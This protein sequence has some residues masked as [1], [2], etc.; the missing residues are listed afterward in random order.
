ML[1]NRGERAGADFWKVLSPE[2]KTIAYHTVYSLAIILIISGLRAVA[3]AQKS[4]G[5]NKHDIRGSSLFEFR[6]LSVVCVL[7]ADF[8]AKEK[9]PA[10]FL[11]NLNR[12]FP[13]E[14]SIFRS[15]KGKPVSQ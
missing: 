9:L 11:I 2:I 14:T 12:D 4:A 15:I 13:N 3:F 8:R 7:P 1:P 5:K 10:V 6:T